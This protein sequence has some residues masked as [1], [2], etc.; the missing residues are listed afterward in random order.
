MLRRNQAEIRHEL[1]GI[2]EAG[3]SPS[4]AANVAAATR[5]IPRSACNARTTGA[6]DQ[7]GSAASIN[8]SKRSRL[9]VAASTAS[10]QSSSTM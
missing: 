4:S 9:A 5:A 2:G 1:A 6:S 7:S 10:M 8:A 3:E